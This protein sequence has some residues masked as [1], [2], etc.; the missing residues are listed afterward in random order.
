MAQFQQHQNNSMRA[1]GRGKSSIQYNMNRY[2]TSQQ[3]RM[4]KAITYRSPH[5]ETL[6]PRTKISDKF[7]STSIFASNKQMM[8]DAF[9][10]KSGHELTGHV[11]GN[12]TQSSPRES[13]NYDGRDEGG[14][15]LEIP[16]DI[17]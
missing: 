11:G 7:G 14:S 13:P 15:Y 8:S 2:K 17:V 1:R 16:D 12:S 3:M 4:D 10:K 5:H 6:Q 9:K